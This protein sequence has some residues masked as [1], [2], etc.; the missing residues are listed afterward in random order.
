MNSSPT[1]RT[2]L[3]EFA[4]CLRS[5]SLGPASTAPRRITR[6]PHQLQ[7]HL[8]SQ[9]PVLVIYSRR[10]ARPRSTAS[11]GPWDNWCRKTPWCATCRES[12]SRPRRTQKEPGT[13][14]VSKDSSRLESKD[15]MPGVTSTS[16]EQP[17]RLHM[18]QHRLTTDS[19][20]TTKAFALCT[21]TC[22]SVSRRELALTKCTLRKLNVV[23]V[24]NPAPALARR[25]TACLRVRRKRPDA[26]S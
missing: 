23:R 13:L 24:P 25:P 3:R 14:E 15:P 18:M 8:S 20:R 6:H 17:T 19:T 22:A 1:W 16:V 5:T 12:G 11:R 21:S 26:T 4:L 10:H 2:T 7:S 9:K